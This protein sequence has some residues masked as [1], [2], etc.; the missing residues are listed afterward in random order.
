MLFLYRKSMLNILPLYQQ[1]KTSKT[2][3]RLRKGGGF[4]GL[5]QVLDVVAPLRFDSRDHLIAPP[6]MP[7][8]STSHKN[9]RKQ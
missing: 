7:T 8:T 3:A 9:R 1:R 4:S 2:Y 6:A 5:K